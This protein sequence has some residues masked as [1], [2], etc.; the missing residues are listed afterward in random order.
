MVA[1]VV[2]AM[3]IAITSN[4][5]PTLMEAADATMNKTVA[6]ALPLILTGVGLMVSILCIFIARAMKNFPAATVLRGALIV[7]PILLAIVSYIILNS[8]GITQSVT[9]I[10]TFGAVGGAL[11]GLITDYYTS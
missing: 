2:S 10:L 1:A 3:A 4:E 11:I 7:P 5:L 6:V 8:L 9:A